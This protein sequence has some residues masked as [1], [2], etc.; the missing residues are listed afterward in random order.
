M[1]EW[2]ALL[3][4][5]A[6]VGLLALTRKGRPRAQAPFDPTKPYSVF[7]GDFDV[8]IDARNLDHI[9]GLLGGSTEEQFRIMESGLT[10]WRARHDFAALDAADRIRSA[11]SKEALQDTVVS[12]LIDHSGSMR[13]QRMLLAAGATTIACDLLDNLGVKQEVLGF[14]TV[15]WRGGRSRKKWLRAGCPP[16]P[17]RLNDLLHIVYCNASQRLNPHDCANMLRP[18][19]LKENLDGEA[20]QWAAARLRK[21][22][23]SRKCII[24]VSDGAPVDDFNADGERWPV[25]GTSFAWNVSVSLRKRA[26]FNCSRSASAMMSIAI[27]SKASR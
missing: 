15:C 26:I 21:R 20:I 8:E 13:G 2:Y 24:V 5:I 10:A 14:T 3:A 16:Y 7:C 17:G 22:Q 11:T 1:V 4:L 19:L 27:T 9:P 12:L 23:E 6:L 18:G 25:S